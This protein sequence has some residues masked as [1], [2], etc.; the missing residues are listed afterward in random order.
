M[1]ANRFHRCPRPPGLSAPPDADH[2]CLACEISPVQHV[3]PMK[4]TQSE[5]L[6]LTAGLFV[7]HACKA[8]PEWV[9]LV[10]HET[11]KGLD[12]S[13]HLTL[14]PCMELFTSSQPCVNCALTLS[15]WREQLH[16]HSTAPQDSSIKTSQLS[17]YTSHCLN[18]ATLFSIQITMHFSVNSYSIKTPLRKFQI[19]CPD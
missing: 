7:M 18:Q 12:W 16:P 11:R 14:V 6:A 3:Q 15:V 2:P 9:G 17:S 13:P 10:I 1:Q 19:L 8:S 5:Q 4:Q